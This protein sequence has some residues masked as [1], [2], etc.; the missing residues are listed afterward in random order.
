MDN[1]GD[2]NKDVDQET[3]PESNEASIFVS[4]DKTLSRIKVIPKCYGRSRSE[5]IIPNCTCIT[6]SSIDEIINTFELE[7]SCK[8][9]HLHIFLFTNF[10]MSIDNQAVYYKSI[11]N[12]I[13]IY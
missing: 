11:S 8:I 3:C 4:K 13:K 9:N 5:N 2:E 7:F 12:I 10:L 1:F 6:R